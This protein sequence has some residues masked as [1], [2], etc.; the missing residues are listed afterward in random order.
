[1]NSTDINVNNTDQV[2]D[3]RL[4][5]RLQRQQNVKSHNNRIKSVTRF[6]TPK[7]K[8]EIADHVLGVVLKRRIG[9]VEHLLVKLGSMG[10]QKLALSSPRKNRSAN[11]YI[12]PLSQLITAKRQMSALLLISEF[13]LVDVLLSGHPL[14]IPDAS[15][16]DALNTYDNIN[17]DKTTE[18]QF[19]TTQSVMNTIDSIL[20]L[21]IQR[22]RRSLGNAFC[23]YILKN[24]NTS[25]AVAILPSKS[26]FTPRGFSL[27]QGPPGTG[28]TTMLVGLLNTLHLQHYNLYYDKLISKAGH[29]ATRLVDLQRNVRKVSTSFTRP[30]ILVV[31]PS[32][33]AVDEIIRRI[34]KNR[35]RAG[36]GSLYNPHLVR[37]GNRYDKDIM[38][39]TL[40]CLAQKELRRSKREIG[41]RSKQFKKES[42]H[43]DIRISKVEKQLNMKDVNVKPEKRIK[44]VYVKQEKSDRQVYVKQEK[45]IQKKSDRQVYI[46]QEKGIQKQRS[47]ESIIR[48]AASA[49][50]SCALDAFAASN[51]AIAAVK[52]IYTE[53]TS[54]S[55]KLSILLH[56]EQGVKSRVE[57]ALLEA[58]DIIFTTLSS[59]GMNNLEKASIGTEF[60][61]AGVVIDEAAQCVELECLIPLR[62]EAPH[63]VL[64]GDP[65]QL[66]A[67]VL[68][69]QA[70][71]QGYGRSLFERLAQ[72][73]HPVRMLN[74]QYRCHPK[75]SAFPSLYFY[76]GKLLD[77]ENVTSNEYDMN[78][79]H[80]ISGHF[81]P[82]IFFNL[83]K[84]LESRGLGDDFSWHNIVEA[85]H[86]FA[87]YSALIREFPNGWENRIGIITPYRAQIKELKKHFGDT[88]NVEI[89][90]V[91]AF[92][93]R[94]KDIIIISCV[95]AQSDKQR[96]VGFLHDIR[97][98]NVAL[99]RAKYGLWILGML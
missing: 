5:R 7:K 11:V 72:R 57:Q 93:G 70:K 19:P 18:Y 17:N 26:Q 49:S 73:G 54:I 20:E 2:D 90:T 76:N 83:A 32:N 61:L 33:A 64:I 95:R 96:D 63:C 66:P 82:F 48:S 47:V 46:K 3:P 38:N 13:R 12:C 15:S 81:R 85:K 53:R 27:V 89:N 75:I 84:S 67:T 22:A 37:L 80:H 56:V 44:E 88:N 23:E 16:L 25:Q 69:Q 52:F 99:T 51:V 14:H 9:Q 45:G 31:A 60:D 92:Q 58:A 50:H 55:S 1:M 10:N 29:A 28:K 74:T 97:R 91:D 65:R 39:V 41:E 98:L 78:F 4:R 59:S 68:S 86:A 40:N 94:E 8:K 30:R 34:I 62:F 42:K 79:H 71:K 87:I 24:F 36:D 35:F 43:A 77:G 6:S 21:S